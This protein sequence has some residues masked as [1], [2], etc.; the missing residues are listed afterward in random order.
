M[1]ISAVL[2]VESRLCNTVAD[3]GTL[4]QVFSASLREIQPR[5]TSSRAAARCLC[6]VITGG[7]GAQYFGLEKRVG[8]L[9]ATVPGAA[10]FP[11]TRQSDPVTLWRAHAARATV[12]GYSALHCLHAGNTSKILHVKTGR[13]TCV[14]AAFFPHN[15]VE[16]ASLSLDP[17]AQP[18]M[19]A[20]GAARFF[21]PPVMP[22]RARQ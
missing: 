13:L 6:T 16:C 7:R 18:R 1:G 20:A 9:A 11:A 2:P 22:T 10:P 17:H 4:G 15:P 19:F 8:K 14:T 5:P 3:Q 21:D 12:D